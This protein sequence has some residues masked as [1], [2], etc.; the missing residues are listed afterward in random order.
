MAYFDNVSRVISVVDGSTKGPDGSEERRKDTSLSYDDWVKKQV[1]AG[2]PEWFIRWAYPRENYEGTNEFQGLTNFGAFAGS[3]FGA[4]SLL[5]Y[6]PSIISAVKGSGSSDNDNLLKA[7][8]G[9]AYTPGKNSG[10]LSGIKDMFSGMS[11]QIGSGLLGI[12]TELGSSILNYQNQVKL[13]DKQNEYNTPKAQMQRFAEAGLNPNLIYG[14]GS[15]GNQPASGSVAPVDFTTAQRENRLAQMQIA[16][17]TKL[18]E[19]EIA[20]K[21]ADMNLKNQQAQNVSANTAYQQLVNSNYLTQLR[22]QLDNLEAQTDNLRTEKRKLEAQAD[23]EETHAR[24][25]LI[26]EQIAQ[27]EKEMSDKRKEYNEADIITGIIGNIF[28]LGFGVNYGRSSVRTYNNG[29]K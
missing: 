7:L 28:H 6:L 17:Q 5:Q 16:T 27:N 22:T 9:D 24:I 13:I 18:A 3:L 15:N 8:Y 21:Q 26:D 14:L 1:S 29:G 11:S 25:A 12:G 23:S 4:G 19:A 10:L 20:D 2:Y